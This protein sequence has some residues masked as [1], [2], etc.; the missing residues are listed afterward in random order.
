MIELEE[1]VTELLI[2]KQLAILRSQLFEF[3]TSLRCDE[4]T[5]FRIKKEIKKI[6]LIIDNYLD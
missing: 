5:Q 2:R 6:E 4:F 3:K 1:I